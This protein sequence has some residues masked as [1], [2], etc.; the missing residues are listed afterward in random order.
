MTAGLLEPSSR[1]SP[2]PPPAPS[3]EM[4]ATLGLDE[5]RGS[6]RSTGRIVAGAAITLGAVLALAMVGRVW[7]G[8][9]PP[10]Y[11]TELVSR[12]PLVVEVSATGALAPVTEVEVGTERRGSRELEA[13]HDQFAGLRVVLLPHLPHGPKPLLGWSGGIL[14]RNRA[15]KSGPVEYLATA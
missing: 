12:G 1:G 15:R 3:P 10:A 4:V 6:S 11:R 9:A 13:A 14:K 8:D 7:G 2:E 5:P